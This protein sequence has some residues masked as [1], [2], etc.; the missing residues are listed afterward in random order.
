MIYIIYILL[1]TF[2][3]LFYHSNLIF[4]KLKHLL[5]KGKKA[6]RNPRVTRDVSLAMM[7]NGLFSLLNAS[8][9]INLLG[10][11]ILTLIG[12]IGIIVSNDK[13]QE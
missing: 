5:Y 1:T 2:F 7:V 4:Q 9:Y 8:S 11:L 3:I 13:I 12:A 10:Y 6:I